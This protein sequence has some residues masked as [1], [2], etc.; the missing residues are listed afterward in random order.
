MTNS[1]M[2]RFYSSSSDSYVDSPVSSTST[3]STTPDLQSGR[4]SE[5]DSNGAAPETAFNPAK[6]SSKL[7]SLAANA[8]AT[9][10]NT[11]VAPGADE[12]HPNDPLL[13]VYD[14]TKDENLS[15][16]ELLARPRRRRTADERATMRTFKG[17]MEIAAKGG[18]KGELGPEQKLAAQKLV[19]QTEEVLRKADREKHKRLIRDMARTL[20]FST[21]PGTK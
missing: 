8:G 14:P 7:T 19:E 17:Q 4:E 9:T 12:G 2:K 6:V 13:R 1:A 11:P 16:E 15:I 10:E 20:E 18:A 5:C 3:T 21:P